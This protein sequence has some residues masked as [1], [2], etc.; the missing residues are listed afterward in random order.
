MTSATVPQRTVPPRTPADVDRPTLLRL[1]TVELRKQ[2]D[3]PV[4]IVLVVVAALLAGVFGGGSALIETN[5]TYGGVARMAAVPGATL[6]PILAIL[7]VTTEITHRT[8]LS[9]YA[10]V[11]RRG[12]VLTAKALASV[13]IGVSVV[14][15]SL[16]AALLIT[17][18]GSAVT[19]HPIAWRADG[20]QIGLFT[21]SVA[22]ATLSGWALGLALKSAP[23]AIVIL[24]VWPMVSST[25]LTLDVGW[26]DVV[27]WL[28]IT[29][30]SG[31]AEDHAAIAVAKV[32]TGIAV[33]VV[34]PAVIGT[35]R[36]LT[37]EVR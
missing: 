7:L 12:R 14:V 36:A 11:P 26:S 29:S 33:W 5:T 8:A 32:L 4:G 1:T 27:T 30:V 24:L 15:L 34:L 19:G 20:V 10:L 2:V 18:V 16:L 17:P 3:T 35:W 21:V 25:I 22:F 37:E 23:A 13:V 31:L 28:D 6:A 9:T